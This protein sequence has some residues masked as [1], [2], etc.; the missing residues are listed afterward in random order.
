M[1]TQDPAR[2]SATQASIE[3]AAGRLKP[4]ALVE[5]CLARIEKREQDV[6]AWACIDYRHALVAARKLDG[7]PP[8]TRLHGIPV[9]VKDV[10]DTA[11]LPTE[12]GSPIYRGHQPACDAACVAQVREA[13]GI[14]LGKTVSTEFATRHPG[15]TRNPANL[16][17]TPGG[18]SS[19]S[20][21][22]VADF[23]VPLAFGTQTSQSILRP[24]AFCGVVGYKPTFGTI[25]RSG[26]KFLSDSLDTLGVMARTVPD[27]AMIV[28]TLAGQAATAFDATGALRPRIGFCRTP[29]WNEADEATRTALEAYAQGLGRSGASVEDVTLP[30]AFAGLAQAQ[31]DVS[32]FE[33]YR[34][35]TWE[36]CNRWSLITEHLQGRIEAGGRVTRERYESGLALGAECR[37][38]MDEVFRPYDVLIAPVARGEAPSGLESTGDPIFGLAWTFLHGPAI[39]LPLLAGPHGLP[40]GV[41]VLGP[42]GGDA[43][44]LQVAQWMCAGAGRTSG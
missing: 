17:H 10:I 30:A 12:Y 4:S 28:E 24:A 14:I 33:F 34:A 44:T 39:S 22:A 21:A 23:M 13:G 3:I 43:R 18:S 6:G 31:I 38:R 5:A 42:R 36:R 11:D 35:L 9:A 16:G 26:M 40:I 1:T 27:A 29:W 8:R 7:E 15:K 25:N 2:L 19:G 41:Q 32:G 20:A 37:T